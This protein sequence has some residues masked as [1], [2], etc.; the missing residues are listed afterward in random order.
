MCIRDRLH[1]PD[2][3]PAGARDAGFERVG[4]AGSDSEGDRRVEADTTSAQLMDQK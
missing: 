1:R 2:R 4:G 3:L